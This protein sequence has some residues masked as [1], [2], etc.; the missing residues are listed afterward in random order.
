M[1]GRSNNFS[2]NAVNKVNTTSQGAFNGSHTSPRKY[3]GYQSI[4][5][6]GS[7]RLTQSLPKYL[8]PQRVRCSAMFIYV[9]VVVIL[10]H[11]GVNTSPSC[12]VY[13]L[14]EQYGVPNRPTFNVGVDHVV[15]EDAILFIFI[16]YASHLRGRQQQVLDMGIHLVY[17][18]HLLFLLVL[19]L[20]FD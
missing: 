16:F 19:F 14:F 10:R 20:F 3:L 15:L 18:L 17:V 13:A 8:G 5:N 11:T 2:K 7:V 6:Y 1:N 12:L 9:A 4:R